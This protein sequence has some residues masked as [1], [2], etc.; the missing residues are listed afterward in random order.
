MSRRHR[1]T[2]TPPSKEAVA[3]EDCGYADEGEE[4]LGLALVAAVQASASSEPG[5][6]ALDDRAVAP[7]PL[8]GIDA[9]AGD[10]V[11]DAALAAIGAGGRS[12]NPCRHG[13]WPGADD[14][15]P[16]GSGSAGSRARAAAGR[17]CRAC[18]RRICPV[19]GAVRSGP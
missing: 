5:H 6:G 1:L 13:A 10:A 15:G 19:T 3:D 18:W 8:R 4:V 7:E 16:A 14:A 9:L 12:R 2:I 11:A 17:G